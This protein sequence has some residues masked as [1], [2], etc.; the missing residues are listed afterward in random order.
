MCQAEPQV[1]TSYS[2]HMLLQQEDPCG[3]WGWGETPGKSVGRLPSSKYPD[4]CPPALILRRASDPVRAVLPR[5]QR[6]G[7]GRP[8]KGIREAEPMTACLLGTQS[9]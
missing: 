8:L 5:K 3:Q 6:R 4:V 7:E 1:S 2:P 9:N